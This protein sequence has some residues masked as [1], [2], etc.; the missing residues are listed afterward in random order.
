LPEAHQLIVH[1][2]ILFVF[3]SVRTIKRHHHH[4]VE[5]VDVVNNFLTLFLYEVLDKGVSANGTSVTVV[6]GRSPE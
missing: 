4:V 2:A 5:L 3:V 1:E 6:N